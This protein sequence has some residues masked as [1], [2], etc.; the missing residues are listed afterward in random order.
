MENDDTR[1]IVEKT[2]EYYD[3][4][5]DEIYRD[6][7]GENVHIGKFENADESL[8]D[9]MAR[10]N[11]EVAERAGVSA[12]DY[13]LDV[14]CG[15]GALARYLAKAY[16]C[17]V[18]ATNISERELDWGRELTQEEG[19]DHL[20]KF[21][22]ADFHALPYEDGMFDQYWSQEAFLHAADKTKV[23]KEAHRVLRDG[24]KLVFTDILVRRDTSAEV[25]QRIYDRVKA[26][27]MWDDEDYV[28]ALEGVGFDLR[29]HEDWSD[30]VALT[31]NWVR[32]Q[33]EN[34]REEFE[35]RIGKEVV[36][37]TSDA[38]QFWVDNA[39]AGRI[40]WACYVAHKK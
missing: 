7:W 19:L 30:N 12:D 6:I 13:I 25:R 16:G 14:G 8:P 28:K 29:V 40:G 37:R 36:D 11:R 10:S 18:L 24:G 20:V 22:W 27:D 26:P 34:R 33:L 21:Q 23:L 35:Q 5:A 31:Y 39:R 38:L 4:A 32:T 2:K 3:G 1:D 9:A 15:Y 17:R